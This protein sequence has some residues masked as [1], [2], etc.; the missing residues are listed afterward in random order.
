MKTIAFIV[1]LVI[2]L[3]S[4]AQE[5]SVAE[6][7]HNEIKLNAFNLMA[8]QAI[9]LSYEYLQH[10]NHTLGIGILFK[11][12]EVEPQDKYLTLEIDENRNFS[13]TPYY[14]RY[15]S[16]KYAKGFFIEGFCML[17]S[18]KEF[19]KDREIIN[20][21]GMIEERTVTS[22]IYTVLHF[23]ISLGIK[24]VSKNDFAVDIYFG[25]GTSPIKNRNMKND[26]EQVSRGGI[27][28]GYRF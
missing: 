5:K 20:E 27:A 9:D 4:H 11:L 6:Y 13:I 15:F 25:V 28:L 19:T 8:Y 17:T 1:I 10:K 2:C 3:T 16:K 18:G 23:G 22:S 12:H 14:R 24:M 21:N 26:I 7:P